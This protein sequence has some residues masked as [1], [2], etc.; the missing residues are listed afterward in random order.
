MAKQNNYYNYSFSVDKDKLRI[1]KEALLGE[2]TDISKFL[3]KAIDKKVKEYQISINC[4]ITSSSGDDSCVNCAS[5]KE[6]PQSPFVKE[7]EQKKLL[8]EQD[9][10][11]ELLGG[12]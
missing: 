4:L 10:I 11:E 7:V 5:F 3:R 9:E 12:K 6:C 2:N 8:L 1:L